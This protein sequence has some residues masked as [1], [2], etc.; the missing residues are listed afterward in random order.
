MKM[1]ARRFLAF[2]LTAVMTFT[3]LAP[4]QADDLAAGET[5]SAATVESVTLP[6]SEKVE[7]NSDAAGDSQWQIR[8]G[9]DLWVDISGADEA[10]L[11]LSYSMVASLLT[12]GTAAVRCKT[13]N[14]DQVS[15][16]SEYQVTVD[17]DAVPQFEPAP[18][19]DPASLVISEA[20][21]VPQDT[22]ETPAEDAG[23]P[24]QVNES[25][26]AIL[27][28]EE[29]MQA[30]E[31]ALLAAEGVAT[32]E[33][34]MTDEQLAALEEARANYEA[35]KAAYD[36][37][38]AASTSSLVAPMMAAAP[39]APQNEG[40]PEVK[41]TYTITIKYVYSTTSQEVSQSVIVEL[42]E[43]ATSIPEGEAFV[44]D[45]P[46]VMGYAPIEDEKQIDLNEYLAKEFPES[47]INGN[48]TITVYYYPVEV[49]YTVNYYWQNLEDDNYTLHESVEETGFT[50]SPV[51]EIDGYENKYKGFYALP[52]DTTTPIAADGSTVV[53][54]Y[55]DR[56]YYLM[57][58]DLGGGYGVE[59]VYARYGAPIEVGTPTRPGYTFQGWQLNN[60]DAQVPPTM[61]A[62]NQNYVAEW[63]AVDKANVTLVFWGENADNEDYSYLGSAVTT[64]VPGSSFTYN[65]DGPGGADIDN[66]LICGKEEHTHTAACIACT[67]THT[68][69]CYSVQNRN[70]LQETTKPAEITSDD[71]GIHTYTDGPWWD[72]EK[73][74]Y[75]KLGDTWYCGYN[76]RDRKDDTLTI[77]LDC[78]HEHTAECYVCGKE[79]HR[80]TTDCYLSS[81][82]DPDL[83][84]LSTDTELN[85]PITVAAD[86]SSVLN[87]YFDRTTFTLTFRARSGWQNE[88]V[89]TIT[90]KWGAEISGRFNEAPFNTTY[91]GR[92]WECTD[93]SK[94]SYALQTLDRMPQFDATFNLYNQSSDDLKT[95]Y[96]YVENVGANVSSD[97]WPGNERDTNGRF[98]LLKTVDTY[99]NYAT[100]EEEYHEIEGFT[101]YSRQAAD[102]N[103]DYQ[104]DFDWN[105]RLDLYY[106]R[107][108]YPLVFNNGYEIVREEQVQYEAPLDSYSEYT[109][110]MPTELYEP[111]SRVFAGWYLNPECS[112]EKYELDEH[113]MPLDGLI[114]YAKWV[115]VTHTVTFHLDNNSMDT[116]VGKMLTISHGEMIE[117]GVPTVE[118][119]RNE[120]NGQYAN[121]GYTFVGW[122]YTDETGA[123]K[124]FDP[125]NMPVNRDLDLYAKWSSNVLKPYV[126][127]YFTYDKDGSKV[128]IAADTT[129]SALAGTT[130]TFEAKSGT[131]LNV[132]Y[133]EG[134][135]PVTRSHSLTIDI[136]DS[137]ADPTI[138]V[139]EFEYVP[140]ELVA[141]TVHYVDEDGRTVHE[142]KLASS[143]NVVVTET[144]VYVAGMM[145]DEAQKRLVL[146]AAP[147]NVEDKTAWEQKYNEITFVYRYDEEHAPVIVEHWFQTV[148]NESEYTLYDQYTESYVDKKIGEEVPAN[149][150]PEGKEEG[151]TFSHA[152]AQHGDSDPISVSAENGQVK[153]VLTDKGLVLRLYYDRIEYPYEICYLEQ[154]TNTVLHEPTRGTARFGTQVWP[155][156]EEKL[157]ITGYR[158]VD[159]EPEFIII[160]SEYV[161]DNNVINLYYVKSTASLT[162]TKKAAENSVVDPDQTFLFHV[163]G[164]GV[165]MYVTVTGTGS[166]TIPNLDVGKEY[167]VTEVTDWSWRYTPDAVQKQVL[168]DADGSTVDFENTREKEQ[169]LDSNCSA[170]NQWKIPDAGTNN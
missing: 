136:N 90:D 33:S 64:A 50:E 32:S 126:I 12:D 10:T 104:K 63:Q 86:G 30:A 152:T 107:N 151:F 95:I 110:E 48:C 62:E 70:S 13:T 145:P 166:V 5:A 116:Q 112:G 125:D 141:Y 46:E 92:A 29:A 115:P 1:K 147:E 42:P 68:L 142:D 139:F 76:S 97:Q 99:F 109:P 103:K 53:E 150:L 165:D 18:Q 14:G 127:R 162:I 67:H 113:T 80:H 65:P 72:Q 74:Y 44:Y 39:A 87:V 96:Y 51:G 114:L 73:H 121:D 120:N 58:F 40:D 133:Q 25:E 105:N 21:A 35:A 23:E 106:L 124:A 17:F 84:V 119:L 34:A 153:V 98:T 38:V 118:E 117:S 111:G 143:P 9:D 81:I 164:N 157:D 16:G 4:V 83:W 161:T 8:A 154:G 61:P 158:L 24:E 22:A 52:Y 59:P 122:F 137:D 159:T 7:L 129:G 49:S 168:I 54:I 27:Q 163:T 146:Q 69:D 57:T 60:E 77:S 140:R 78:T 149:I 3:L 135:F 148:G 15:Y 20:Q 144:Y 108:D 66:I 91:N 160:Q 43:G 41:P 71:D 55:Y 94:Y 82:L 100:Y 26:A 11:Q 167:T 170:E 123:E 131:Q 156:E 169:W 89:A 155:S 45:S 2:L 28:A 31:E 19:P 134:Y 6:V 138:N 75:L 37:A 132:G 128:Y 130:K 36:E 79:Q 85:H 101:R 56:Y 93:I 102:F 47:G 88:T